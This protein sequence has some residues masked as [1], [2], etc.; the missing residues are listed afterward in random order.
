MIRPNSR[1]HS[2]S[3]IHARLRELNVLDEGRRA[4]ELD[5]KDDEW[6]W[7]NCD[8]GHKVTEE[9]EEGL[10]L[11]LKAPRVSLDSLIRKRKSV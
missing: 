6:M 5:G 8:T 4:G 11:L 10:L 9:R 1:I 7:E 2:G 3:N